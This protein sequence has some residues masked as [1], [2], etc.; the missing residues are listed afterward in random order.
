M[1]AVTDILLAGEAL[2]AIRRKKAT[3]VMAT[4]PTVLPTMA[5]VTAAGIMAM[6]I[7]TAVC[8]AA[9]VVAGV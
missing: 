5:I 2:A 4:V 7:S 6:D 8:A 3:T 1:A 9:M